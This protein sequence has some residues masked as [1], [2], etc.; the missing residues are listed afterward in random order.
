MHEALANLKW[1]MYFD[2]P[3]KQDADAIHV[4]F[5]WMKLNIPSQTDEANL[6]NTNRKNLLSTIPIHLGYTL[7]AWKKIEERNFC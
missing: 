4:S 2:L 3:Q 6:K 5:Q 1:L 7:H